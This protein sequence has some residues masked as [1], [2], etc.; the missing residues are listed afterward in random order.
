LNETDVNS[1]RKPLVN[2]C[3]HNYNSSVVCQSSHV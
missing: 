3:G 1:Y 2:T